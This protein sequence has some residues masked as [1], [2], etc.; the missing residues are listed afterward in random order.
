[1][2]GFI[3]IIILMLAMVGSLPLRAEE[4]RMVQPI[5]SSTPPT[6]EQQKLLQSW[7]AFCETL[8]KQGQQIIAFDT[9]APID[10]AEGFHYLAMLSALTIERV[11]FSQNVTYPVLV[12]AIDQHK[13]VGLDSPDNKYYMTRFDPEGEYV[14]KGRRGSVP[15]LGFQFNIDGRAVANLNHSQMVFEDDGTFELYLTREQQG[16][17]W[18]A[19]PEGTNGLYVR[20]IFTKWDAQ[21]PSTMWLERVD[22]TPPAKQL[23]PDDLAQEFATMGE[24][25]SRDIVFWQKYVAMNKQRAYNTISVPRDT[26]AQGGSPDNLYSGGYFD[27]KDDEALLI[28][29]TPV[30]AAYWAA[31]LGNI[32]FQSLDYQQAQTSLNSEQIVLDKDGKLRLIVAHQ[33]PGYANWL[34]TN[35]RQEGVIYMRWNRAKTQPEAIATRVVKIAELEKYMPANAARVTAEARAQVMDKRYR[36]VARRFAE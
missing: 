29:L 6:P 14:I 31:Q 32:W 15:Y 21:T 25:I 1:M 20:E 24:K 22:E 16:Q 19:L 9:G 35:G 26:S 36:A 10:S 2:R 8:K 12:R 23:T 5:S 4:V 34:D 3:S 28:E 33:D 7:E 27:L 30:E 17:N 11:Q 13:K 18:L